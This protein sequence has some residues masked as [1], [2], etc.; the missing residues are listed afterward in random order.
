MDNDYYKPVNIPQTVSEKTQT[1]ED[2]VSQPTDGAPPV[3]PPVSPQV[4]EQVNN[5]PTQQTN[6]ALATPEPVSPPPQP[7]TGEPTDPITE[8]S[9]VANTEVS[10]MQDKPAEQIPPTP[11]MPPAP[12]PPADEPPSL[13]QPENP[14]DPLA[15]ASQPNDENEAEFTNLINETKEKIIHDLGFANASE[16]QKNSV[17]ETLD[18]RVTIAV[19]Q[20]IIENSSDEEAEKIKQ[21][22][23]D[24]TKLEETVADIVRANPELTEKIKAKV[25]DLYQ[26]ILEESKRVW[27]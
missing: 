10:P 16:E 18:Q 11:E 12:T 26:K 14:A 22:I 5:T 3:V 17:L 23:D 13:T 1:Q 27:E 24:D 15:T 4:A 19:T 2:A 6:T 7:I 9:P 25:Q 20:A 21:V 8:P